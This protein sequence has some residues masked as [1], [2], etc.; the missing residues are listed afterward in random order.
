MFLM[1]GSDLN[2]YLSLVK[3]MESAFQIM[4]GKNDTLQFF[5]ISPTL[6]PIIYACYF[7]ANICFALNI[8]ISIITDA[9]D[10]VRSEAKQAD[11]QFDCF[12]HA[13]NRLKSV[14][15]WNKS[16]SGSP[17]NKSKYRDHLSILSKNINRMTNF[18]YRVS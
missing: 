5:M 11:N 10:Q 3:S 1:Y 8:F 4:L 17:L 6:G 7:L 18:I 12:V 13:L 16:A 9:F 2:G 14:I 15:L